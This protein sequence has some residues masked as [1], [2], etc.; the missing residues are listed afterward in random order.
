MPKT[1]ASGRAWW[2][3]LDFGKLSAEQLIELLAACGEDVPRSLA[4]AIVSRGAEALPRLCQLASEERWWQEEDGELAL[5]AMHLLGAIGDPSATSALLAPLRRN[6]DSDIITEDMPGVLARLGPEAMPKLREFVEDSSQDSVMRSVAY[7]GLVGMSVLHPELTEQVKLIG[8]D[9]ATRCLL[10]G[11]PIPAVLGIDLAEF[12]DPAD[13]K[14]LEKLHERGLW[15]ERA[16][17]WQEVL[18]AFREGR[19]DDQIEHATLD[20]MNWFRSS[21]NHS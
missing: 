4:E 14:I 16:F 3:V 9:V 6:E 10:K 12:Q 15:E 19:P 7:T 17:P 2:Q 13:G 5:H 1:G 8:R 21:D 20:P 11:E 18:D